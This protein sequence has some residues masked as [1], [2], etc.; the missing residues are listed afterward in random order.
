[1][2]NPEDAPKPDQVE[3][4]SPFPW[5]D[6]YRLP[7]HAVPIHYEI[8]VLYAGLSYLEGKVDIRFRVLEDG[9]NFI[10][11][12]ARD[13]GETIWE[14][15]RGEESPENQITIKTYRKDAARGQVY[16]EFGE[17]LK[18]DVEYLFQVDYKMVLHCHVDSFQLSEYQDSRTGEE[19]EMGVTRFQPVS[20]R[21]LFPC[22]DEPAM[23]AT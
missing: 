12:N 6:A 14:M 18:Q 2:E 19:A 21:A 4:T 8:S 7:T 15:Y 20:A 1:M 10:V 16:V 22:F 23:K 17:E 5:P 9:K 11:L 3:D 13:C